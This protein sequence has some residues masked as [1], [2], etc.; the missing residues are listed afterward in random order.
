MENQ[1]IPWNYQYGQRS[2]DMEPLYYENGLLYISK[3]ET[4][5]Q[6]A[7]IGEKMYPMIVDHLYGT[8]DIDT[9]DDLK[10][11]EFIMLQKTEI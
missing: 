5:L 8:I 9:I 3:K 4:I 11:A 10:Y 1:F 7:I 2:Q 6:G